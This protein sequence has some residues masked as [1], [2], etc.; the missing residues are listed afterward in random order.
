MRRRPVARIAGRRRAR[1]LAPLAGYRVVEMAHHLSAPLASMYLA[2][3]GADVV[4]VESLEGEDWRRWGR[5]SPA[6]MSQLFLAINRNK[7]SLSLDLGVPAGR[8]V[9]ERLLV[10]ADVLLT[11]WAPQ[12]LARLG[13]DARRL[14]RRHP[15][16]VVARLSG[17]G[18]RGPEAD[19]RAFD[20]VVCGETGLLLPHPTA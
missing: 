11:N 19:R 16:L 12:A 6:G 7:R 3:F 18:T 14:A 20:I 1:A 8:R 2:D 15:R 17:F 9:L 13:L 4:K 5:P 10:S